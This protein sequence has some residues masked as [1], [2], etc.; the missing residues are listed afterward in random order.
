MKNRTTFWMKTKHIICFSK[1]SSYDS[2][3]QEL[4]CF[5]VPDKV[6]FFLTLNPCPAE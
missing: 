1:L 2:V 3:Y 6:L 4:Y 5:I